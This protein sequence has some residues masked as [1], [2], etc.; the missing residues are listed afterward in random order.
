MHSLNTVYNLA[1]SKRRVPVI[2]GIF[3][4]KIF[5]I[6]IIYRNLL[7]NLFEFNK[8]NFQ[9]KIQ[10][11]FHRRHRSNFIYPILQ[12]CGKIEY[13]YIQLCKIPYLSLVQNES[14]S[15]QYP[16]HSSLTQSKL[17]C[18]YTI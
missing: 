16:A 17:I 14:T 8:V 2:Y 9:F 1:L 13:S 12:I 18:P 7:A 11:R 4:I 5:L 15:P 10:N 3:K 6:L